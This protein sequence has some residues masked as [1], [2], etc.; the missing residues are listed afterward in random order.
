MKLKNYIF[1][2][3]ISA[4]ALMSS[5][6]SYAAEISGVTLSEEGKVQWVSDEESLCKVELFHNGEKKGNSHLT[7][8]DTYDLSP[9]M[10]EEGYYFCRVSSLS[11]DLSSDFSNVVCPS[12]E[13]IG[14]NKNE[15]PEYADPED[16]HFTGWKLTDEGWRWK[17]KD[18]VYTQGYWLNEG[19][20][21]YLLDEEGYLIKDQEYTYLGVKWRF[22]ENGARR[23]KIF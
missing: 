14:I 3:I 7:A 4:L 11:G 19:E 9:L 1:A 23:E 10:D 8:Y 20:S 22:D 6:R 2:A 16:P 15:S 13:T 12:E 18:G 17:E 21:V 5:F